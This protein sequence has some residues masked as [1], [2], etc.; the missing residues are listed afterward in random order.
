MP[1]HETLVDLLVRV[2]HA[3]ATALQDR[4]EAPAAVPQLVD[5]LL[6]GPA[7]LH[8]VLQVFGEL[9]AGV[10]GGEVGYLVEGDF[11]AEAVGV[12]GVAAASGWWVALPLH[13]N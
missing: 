5:E 6:V 4:L 3:A 8:V 9:L 11:A 2:L 12:V 7:E 13:D 1:T 10:L